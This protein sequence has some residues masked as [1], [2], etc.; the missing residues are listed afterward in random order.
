[1]RELLEMDER[2]TAILAVNDF[3]TFGAIKAIREKGLRIPEDIALI[4]FDDPKSGAILEVPLTTVRQPSREIGER[5]VQILL[6]E[7]KEGIRNVTRVLLPAKLV[8][9]RSCG[10]GVSIKSAL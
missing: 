2:P 9:R 10:A 5:A 7:I 3:T 4:G 6:T 1:M 8:I